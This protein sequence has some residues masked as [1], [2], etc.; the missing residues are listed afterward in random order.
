MGSL[1]SCSRSS[2]IKLYRNLGPD[3]QGLANLVLCEWVNS[4]EPRKQ[5]AALVL[6]DEFE[7][8]EALPRLRQLASEIEE[9]RTDIEAPYDWARVN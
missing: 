1:S 5:F 7:I 3:E 8:A 9:K 2:L 6:I 4:D